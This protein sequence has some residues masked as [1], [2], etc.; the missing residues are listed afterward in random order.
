M[1]RKFVPNGIAIIG[2]VGIPNRYG[3]FESFA[4][5]IAPHLRD[6]YGRIYVTCDR[7]FYANDCESVFNGVNRI[8]INIRANGAFS[9]LHDLKAYLSVAW[10][11]R[12]VLI[13]GVSGGPFFLL[14]RVLSTWFRAAKFAVNVDGVEWRRD[15][16]GFLRKGIL[17]IFD[18]L[19][20]CMAYGVIFDNPELRGYVLRGKKRACIA[21]SGD[22]VG[23]VNLPEFG[24]NAPD[25]AYALTICRI[26]PENNCHLLIE[27]FLRSCLPRYVF[28]GSWN[29]SDYAISLR[30][31][32]QSETRI[33]FR[34][35][36]FDPVELHRLRGG[37]HVYLHGHSVGGTN[38]SLVEMLFYD[39]P[40]I[41]FDCSF[42][43]AT[44]GDAATY[45]DRA[46]LLGSQ[47][48]SV[49]TTCL[50]SRRE[51][52]RKYTA[53]S[54]ATQVHEFLDAL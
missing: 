42:N 13:L 24:T 27:G 14:F 3:G 15:K 16:Y 11:V 50:E 48:D 47:I 54:I 22:H 28:V 1:N 52:R 51:L 45:F 36:T 23:A 7:E 32:Y 29:H 33:Q 17:Y 53:V 31:K 44:A 30:K 12:R 25:E 40:I 37:C 18:R 39:A 34:D 2:C 5:H 20:Q 41:C 6:L 38:P 49:E 46:D 10:K 4:E 35:A 43:R 19:A 9:P 26:E 21:Y 8:F